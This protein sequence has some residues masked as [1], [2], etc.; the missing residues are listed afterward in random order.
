MISLGSKHAAAPAHI[1]SDF[2]S[3][4]ASASRRTETM[5]AGLF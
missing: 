2:G 4:H 5:T 3:G 1:S